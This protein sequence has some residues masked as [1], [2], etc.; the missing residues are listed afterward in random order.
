MK[1]NEGKTLTA[2]WMI[3]KNNLKRKVSDSNDWQI[4]VF[5][6]KSARVAHCVAN[7]LH[8][9]VGQWCARAAFSRLWQSKVNGAMLTMLLFATFPHGHQLSA[10]RVGVGAAWLWQSVA[11]CCRVVCWIVGKKKR[12][13]VTCAA[14]IVGS[15]AEHWAEVTSIQK[16]KIITQLCPVNSEKIW[17][18]FAFQQWQLST[19]WSR[20]ASWEIVDTFYHHWLV[21]RVDLVLFLVAK[22]GTQLHSPSPANLLRSSMQRF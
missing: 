1:S 4:N 17:K 6:W 21:I 18:H 12:N 20:G 22:G 9:I 19:S 7:V 15:K 3:A 16:L 5:F 8:M 13:E 11:I 10:V 2:R 14:H